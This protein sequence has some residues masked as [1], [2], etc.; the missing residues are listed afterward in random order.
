M[1]FDTQKVKYL[2]DLPYDGPVVS[3]YY[4][5]VFEFFKDEK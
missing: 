2:P 4:H 5:E 1:N 3:F